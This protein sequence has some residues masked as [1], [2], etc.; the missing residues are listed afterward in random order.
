MQ[1]EKVYKQMVRREQ[2]LYERDRSHGLYYYKDETELYKLCPDLY[3]TEKKEREA[4]GEECMREALRLALRDLSNLRP[5]WHS[6][7]IDYYY[8]EKV[9]QSALGKKYGVSH[10]TISRILKQALRILRRKA[11]MHLNQLLNE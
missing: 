3:D 10:Q 1:Y 9:T 11:K 5:K 2:Y 7:V 4:F 8:G 6:I